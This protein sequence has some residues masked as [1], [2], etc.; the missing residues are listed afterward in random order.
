[1]GD[2]AANREALGRLLLE[3]LD[4]P[5]DRE[6]IAA[7][8]ERRFRKPQAIVVMDST[9]FSR[10]VREGGIIHYLA[11]LKR[12]EGHLRPVIEGTGGRELR[13]EAD[14]I[15]AVF[16]DV[17]S[18]LDGAVACL[19]EVH[20]VN[21]ALPDEEDVYVS[22]GLGYGEVLLVDPDDLFGD[23]MNLACKLGEDIAQRDEI[24]L[25]PAARAALTDEQWAFE[26]L[27]LSISG[28]RLN[29]F[30]LQR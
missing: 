27:D 24:L 6:R 2:H 28:L 22:M 5:D 29:A 3:Y 21:E 19:A 25:T 1:V 15:F 23:E 18:A 7:E 13:T 17:A 11:L 20:R 16:P 26:E 14:N 30:R 8:I 9:G 12:L 10:S 4:R